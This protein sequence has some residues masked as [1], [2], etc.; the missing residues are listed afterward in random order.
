MLAV[1]DQALREKHADKQTTLW[2]VKKG[3]RELE[4]VA[5][6]VATGLDLRLL[7]RGEMLRTELCRDAFWLEARM[8]LWQQQLATA[9][10][11]PVVIDAHP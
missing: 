10:W 4:C 8:K 7:E 3:E 2:R 1:L 11:T 5:V 6:Y 9:G